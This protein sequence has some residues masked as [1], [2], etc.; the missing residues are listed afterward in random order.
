[1]DNAPVFAESHTPPCVQW[2]APHRHDTAVAH[3]AES[4]ERFSQP[5]IALHRPSDA[6][7]SQLFI[8][9][10][11]TE[12]VRARWSFL[13]FFYSSFFHDSDT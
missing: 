10:L 6:Y 9:R 1:M 12:T 8:Q 5:A 4:R 13:F 11:A 3:R 7:S 2:S